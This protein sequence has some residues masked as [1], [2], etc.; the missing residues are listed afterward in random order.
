[1]VCGINVTSRKCLSPNSQHGVLA[2]G[3]NAL[4]MFQSVVRYLFLP[5]AAGMFYAQR[6][7]FPAT[8][9]IEIPGKHSNNRWLQ[10]FAQSGF[11]PGQRARVPQ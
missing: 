2:V 1:M 8:E 6:Q 5:L 3:V 9:H 7:M 11:A 4:G 10:A